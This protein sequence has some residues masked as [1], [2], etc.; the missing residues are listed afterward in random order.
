[1]KKI[2]I[3]LIVLVG[4]SVFIFVLLSVFTF[5]VAQTPNHG[6]NINIVYIGNSITQGVQLGGA[7]YA[8]PAIAS[9]ILS[10]YKGIASVD[11][12][13][14][15]V[16]GKT[17]FDHMPG[18]QY[19]KRTIENA[20]G[21]YGNNNSQLVFSIMI[22]TNDS[23]AS[24]PN[25]APVAKEVYIINL[26]TIIDSLFSRYPEALVVLHHPIWYSPNTYNTSKYLQEGLDR[27]QS[28]IPAID[29]LAREYRKKGFDVYVGDSKAHKYFEKNYKELMIHENGQEGIFFLHPNREGAA[30]LAGFWAD[31][32]YRALR[33]AGVI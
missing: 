24:G 11:F 21:F 22:G 3:A 1:M 30:K 5:A 28:Y 32:I 2:F 33:K 14:N 10:E 27:M 23:A 16:S 25:G 20:D 19:F 4:V 13:N 6:K 9:G 31:G 18:T 7:E 12:Y 26:I 15:G 29:R 8:P 17:T